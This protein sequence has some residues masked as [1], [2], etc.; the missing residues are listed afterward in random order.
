[1]RCFEDRITYGEPPYKFEAGTPAI[2]Q[3]IGLGSAIDYVN[4]VGKARIPRTW[5]AA[6][7]RVRA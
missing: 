2:V 1:M 6:L 3:A 4:S 5:R 7:V